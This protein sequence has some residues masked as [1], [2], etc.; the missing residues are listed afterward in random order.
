MVVRPLEGEEYLIGKGLDLIDVHQL[1]LLEYLFLEGCEEV[2]LLIC[3]S[4]VD[5]GIYS[6]FEFLL[7]LALCLG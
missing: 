5:V 2:E 4:Q 1:E 7:E 3:H 6:Y